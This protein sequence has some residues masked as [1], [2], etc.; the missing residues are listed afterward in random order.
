MPPLEAWEKVL[1]GDEFLV[2]VHNS[3][4]CI[5]CHGGVE[6]VDDKDAA[7]EGVVRDPLADSERV[8]GVCHAE[9]S[10]LVTTS[11]HQNLTGYH[12]MLTARGADFSDPRVETA[13]DN[14]CNTCHTTCGQCHVSRPN[15]T[16]G[17]LIADHKVKEIASMKDTCM[18]C[19]GAR[20]SNEYQ[21]KNEGVEG[22]V[23]WLQEGMACFDCH[24][25]SDYHG[26]G[27]EYAHRYD[28]APGVNCLDCHSEVAPGQT[29][30]EEHTIHAGKVACNVCHVSGEYK[31]CYNCHV[32]VDEK[33]IPY[34]KTDESKLTFKI[35]RNPYKSE[36]RPWDYVLV[37]HIPV[38]PDIFDFYGDD[39]LPT[40]ENV[41]TW[42]YATP[43]NIQRNTP[44][45]QS[46]DSCHGNAALFLTADDVAPAE[47]EANAAVIVD[48]IP[49]TSWGPYPEIKPTPATPQ[50]IWLLGGV[51]GLIVVGGVV[52]GVIVIVVRRRAK[53]S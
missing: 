35:G 40:F 46:C 43:H 22:S 21:G 47:R 53:G 6:G 42:K 37:R 30:I 3:Q 18:A 16:F 44:Q 52:A 7:H 10:Q 19:H 28:G 32:G 25:T 33:G 39:L 23:H 50:W 49:P 48:E 2:S 13:F 20:V 45:N 11:L 24:Q 8:C 12:T 1:V 36:D 31:S 34:Y 17:G 9:T 14:H 27:T 51:L 5:G 26:D 41:S 29:T 4:N 38:T 15:F